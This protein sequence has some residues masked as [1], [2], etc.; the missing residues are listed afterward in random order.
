MSQLRSVIIP[1]FGVPVVRPEIPAE[2][3]A[4]RCDAA[5]ERA[6]KTWLFVYADRE[7]NASILHFTG[8]DP[9]FEEAI[10][11]LGPNGRRVIIAGNESASFTA[12]S[13]L[14]D[15][16]T[17]LAQ[18]LSLMGQDRTLAPSLEGILREIG[19]KSG[20]T[21]GVIG[22]KYLDAEEWGGDGPAFLVPHYMIAIL[23][24]II[25]GQEGLSDETPLVLNPR[26]GLRTIVDVDQ[27]AIAE[28]ASARASN[29]VWSV[30]K[31]ARPGLREIEAAANFTYSGEPLSAHSMFS[32]GNASHQI[33]G[34]NNPGPRVMAKGDGVTTAVGYWGA[35]SSRAGILDDHNDAFVAVAS[36]YFETLVTWYDTADIGVAGGTLHDAIGE[37]LARGGLKSALNAGH[38]VNYDEWS[39]SPI[40]P[41]STDQLRSG[42]VFQVDI[43]PTQI[44]AGTAL[45]CEDAIAIADADLRAELAAKH[46]EAWARINAR[47]DF[48]RDIV[49]V[50]L[51]ESILPLSNIPLCLPP[52]WLAADKIFVND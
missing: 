49:G 2:T 8:F 44:P 34:L 7:H 4:A 10:L 24:R 6:G 46:P 39:H 1:D 22:W 35:L 37:R 21:V 41:N 9:R 14:P 52:L 33:H 43:I 42:M 40:R 45:N 50:D 23:A 20:D 13:P 29:S 16:E 19:L 30:L 3:L 36:H 31:G 17:Y 38:L 11:L 25:G 28:W 51:K 26:D 18:T 15:V 47:R 48:M 12:I 5:Y 27:I 32:S